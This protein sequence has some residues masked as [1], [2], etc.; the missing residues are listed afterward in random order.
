M[1]TFIT[2]SRAEVGSTAQHYTPIINPEADE[3]LNNQF[4]PTAV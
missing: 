2:F 3:K 1:N 4:P